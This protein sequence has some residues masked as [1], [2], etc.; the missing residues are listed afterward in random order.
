LNRDAVVEGVVEDRV[1]EMLKGVLVKRLRLV[2]RPARC[3]WAERAAA[4][5]W[6]GMWRQRRVRL[7][8]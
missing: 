5:E 7:R 1:V 3:A 8:C 4:G 2:S 6:S